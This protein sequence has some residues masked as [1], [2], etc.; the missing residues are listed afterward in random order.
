MYTQNTPVH[1]RLWNR[2]FW[3]LAVANLMLTMAVCMQMVMA[4][5]IAPSAQEAAWSMAAFAIGMLLAGPFVSFLVERF[6]RNKVCVNAIIIVAACLVLPVFWSD[7]ANGFVWVRAVTG[8]GYGLAGMVLYSTLVVDTC[9]SHQRTEANYAVAWFGR[10]ALA[11]GPFTALVLYH[12]WGGTCVAWTAT[13]LALT[14]MVLVLVVSCPFRFP[15]DNRHLMSFD[16]FILP[17]AWLLMALLLIIM[18]AVGMVIATQMNDKLFFALLLVGFMMAIIAEKIV[19]VNAELMSEAVAGL[20]LLVFALLLMMVR[21]EQASMMAPVMVGL[22]TGI[23]GSRFLLFFIKLSDHCQRGTSQSS[24]FIV[25]ETGLAAGL[26]AGLGRMDGKAWDS[27]IHGT[28]HTGVLATALVL[29]VL[30]LAVYVG[31][32]HKWYL[33]HKNR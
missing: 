25:W 26:T 22:G 10:L 21:G 32:A 12:K 15:D 11:L 27:F 1:I 13:A 30:A 33:K 5:R 31:V 9:E 24:F 19:F 29:V 4:C 3:H 2:D 8:A 6:R 20:V 28:Q 17:S 18:A 16:R 14:A 23:V 7:V